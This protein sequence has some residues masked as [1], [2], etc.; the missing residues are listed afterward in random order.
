MSSQHQYALTLP[1]LAE[2]GSSLEFSLRLLHT[3]LT[4]RIIAHVWMWGQSDGDISHPI[5]ARV[6]ALPVWMNA[7]SSSPAFLMLAGL[8]G[9]TSPSSE[10]LTEAIYLKLKDD[11][12]MKIFLSCGK[13]QEFK[14]HFPWIWTKLRPL[15]WGQISYYTVIPKNHEQT[16]KQ[17]QSHES[18]TTLHIFLSWHSGGL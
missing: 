9:E 11:W 6:E 14:D 16:N 8:C 12:V 4:D 1:V 7:F 18:H 10:A 15:F 5:T 2:A 3:D 13:P 17:K